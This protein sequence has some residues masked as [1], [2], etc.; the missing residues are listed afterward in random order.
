MKTGFFGKDQGRGWRSA[1]VQSL[2]ELP[3][4]RSEFTGRI[5]DQGKTFVVA[6][7]T[8]GRDVSLSIDQAREIGLV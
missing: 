8:G 1:E 6:T 7:T 2:R 5:S 4:D 3:L